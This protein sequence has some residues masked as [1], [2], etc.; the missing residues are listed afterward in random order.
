M[1]QTIGKDLNLT[2]VDFFF[3]IIRGRCQKSNNNLKIWPNNVTIVYQ[4]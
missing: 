2:L 1:R 3:S 4:N